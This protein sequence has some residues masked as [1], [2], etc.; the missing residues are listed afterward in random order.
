[1]LR[2]RNR[3]Q[4]FRL[5]S[6]RRISIWVHNLTHFTCQAMIRARVRKISH[7]L[8]IT[9]RLS[10]ATTPCCILR[11]AEA[12]MVWL[13]ILSPIPSVVTILSPRCCLSV[14]SLPWYPLPVRIISSSARPRISLRLPVAD[15]PP[16]WRRPRANSASSSFWVHRPASWL[17][18]LRSSMFRN[19]WPIRLFSG[20]SICSSG[21]S[22]AVSWAISCWSLCCM[23]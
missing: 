19:A 22:S 23:P 16:R 7:F 1:M 2:R 14:L 9:G 5:P 17:P 12:A 15:W 13:V 10:S 4:P 20:H 21:Y 8:N 11:S 3:I 6:I 18:S